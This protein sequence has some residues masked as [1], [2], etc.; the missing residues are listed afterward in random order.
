MTTLAA[1]LKDAKNVAIERHVGFGAGQP[2]A[3]KEQ[4]R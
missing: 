1:L 3:E 2:T 4:Y